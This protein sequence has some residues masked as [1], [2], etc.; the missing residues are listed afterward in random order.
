MNPEE[1]IKM[2][3]EQITRLW[4]ERIKLLDQIEHLEALIEKIKEGNI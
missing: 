3:E 1:Q 2:I 4:R